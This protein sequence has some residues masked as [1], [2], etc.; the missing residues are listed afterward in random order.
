VK[1]V[2]EILGFSHNYIAA[3]NFDR[4][5]T[6]ILLHGTGG[7]EFDMLSLGRSLDPQANLLSPRGK[8]LENGQPRFFRRV[9][10]GVF[11]LEDLKVRTLELADFTK[12][13]SANYNFDLE[14]I[15]A[16]GFSNGANIAGSLLLLVPK[17]ITGAILLRPLLPF[18]PDS[19][20]DLSGVPVLISAGLND[21][22]V[23]PEQPQK[24]SELLSKAGASVA[25]R[26]YNSGHNLIPDEIEY[27]R[28]WLK[29]YKS[30]QNLPQTEPPT[31]I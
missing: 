10:E 15:V 4:P 20:P 24:L 14:K 6:L 8:V 5:M 25:L 12:V 9:R 18:A 3:Q 2:K 23:P 19:I 27:A 17:L 30:K 29:S 13:A 1:Q 28:E 31:A 22:A 7:D 21:P 16:V 26:W 11:D